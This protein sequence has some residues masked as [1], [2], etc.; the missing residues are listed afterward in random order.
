MGQDHD[1]R[2]KERDKQVSRPRL[3]LVQTKLF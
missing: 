2:K 3:Y 1:G